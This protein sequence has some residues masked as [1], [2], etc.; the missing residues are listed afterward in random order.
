M[1]CGIYL[2]EKAIPKT[3]EALMRSRYTAYSMANIDYIKKT[4]RGKPLVNFNE[5]EATRWAKSVQ[6]MGLNVIKPH[7]EEVDKHIGFVEFIA[8]YLDKGAI[9]IIHEI[10]QFQFMNGRWFYIDGE[11]PQG[12]SS[13]RNNIL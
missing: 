3:P 7:R 1:C 11:H 6:W 4:M 5:I 12:V 13:L 9:K 10:S 2:S 8:T